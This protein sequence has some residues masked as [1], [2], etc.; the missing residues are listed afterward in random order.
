MLANP[1]P[2]DNDPSPIT[3]IGGTLEHH[4]MK[5]PMTTQSLR[6]MANQGPMHWRGDRTGGN[7]EPTAQPNSGAYNE[8]LGFMKFQVAFEGLL[9]RSGPI[10]DADMSAFGDFILQVTYPP[11]P[12]RNLDDSDTPDQAV[13]RDFFINTPNSAFLTPATRCNDCHRLDEEANAQYGIQRPGFFGSNDN[14]SFVFIPMLLKNPH[15]RNQYQKIGMFGSP[16][17]PLINPGDNEHMGDQVRGFGYFHDGTVDTEFRFVS[18]ILFS[19]IP[20]V[21]D[22]GIPV[23]AEGDA[24]RR[25][26][27]DFMRAFPSNLK[28]SVGQQ[29]T[30]GGG[31]PASAQGRVDFLEGRS[32]A[33]H[34][35]L[36]EKARPPGPRER[37]YL[38]LNNGTYLTDVGDTITSADLRAIATQPNGSVTFTCVPRGSG[39][40]IG[41]DRDG[42][43]VY[44]G[45]E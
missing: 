29:I 14:S 11:N 43:G 7:D 24:L 20:G 19:E 6:G 32:T 5:G 34:C 12:I 45:Q 13:A 21:N 31:V 41:I 9:G 42:D 27:A 10:P 38:Y 8:H 1:G 18:I 26:L 36:V 25:K 23:N 35:E 15:L 2:F 3:T 4:P 22:I 30:L 28:P 16:P 44:D 39:T 17:M 37:G 40:R 33:G